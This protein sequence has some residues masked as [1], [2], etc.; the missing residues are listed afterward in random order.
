MVLLLAGTAAVVSSC[1]ETSREERQAHATAEE[2]IYDGEPYRGTWS[3]IREKGVLRVLTPEKGWAALPRKGELLTFEVDMARRLAS[4]LGVDLA[5]VFAP[6]YDSIIPMLVAGRADVAMASL[7]AT[8]R[9]QAFVKFSTPLGYVRELLIGRPDDTARIRSVA[10]LSGREVY[11]RPS[12]SYYRTLLTIKD[13]VPELSIQ[14]APEDL[15]THEIVHKVARGKYPLTVCDSDIVDAVLEYETGVAVLLPLTGY[16]PRAWAVTK[17]C[18]TLCAKLNTFIVEESLTPHR[19]ER[20]R[21]DLPEIKKR[22]TLRVATRN[23][24]ATYWIHRGEEVGFE[25]ELCRAF[26]KEH[27]LRLEMR[28]A[29]D[30]AVLLDW[31]NNGEADIAAACLTVTERRLERVAF[32]EPYLFP[33]EVIVSGVDSTGKPWVADTSGLFGA[34]VYVRRSSSYFGTLLE[35]ARSRGSAIDI[36][37]VPEEMETEEILRREIGRA[38]V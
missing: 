30:R 29:P 38:H 5:F 25:Y 27:D 1:G 8:E 9:R 19:R 23:N 26:A 18:D 4:R 20:H 2:R 10:D 16:R 13:S 14:P 31:V 21:G 35:L 36:R 34:P 37:I 15:H 28:V 24:A 17:G 6:S 32:C 22:R 12:S 3:A 11:V 7:T 33:V